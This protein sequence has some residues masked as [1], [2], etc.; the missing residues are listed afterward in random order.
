MQ[1]ETE[2]RDALSALGDR[3]TA[4]EVRLAT[5]EANQEA[6]VEQQR[7]IRNFL[8]G[9]SVGLALQ[10]GGWVWFVAT[11]HAEQVSLA[12]RVAVLSQR[13]DDL[14]IDYRVRTTPPK[15]QPTTP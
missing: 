1:T 10:I 2:F 7:V 11:D 3:F 4:I 15:A 13:V 9:I 8:L 12:A 14:W 6:R 5:I